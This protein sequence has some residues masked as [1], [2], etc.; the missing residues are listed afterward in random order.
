MNFFD[1]NKFFLREVLLPF[2]VEHFNKTIMRRQARLVIGIGSYVRPLTDAAIQIGSVQ[3]AEGNA[4][5]PLGRA[6]QWRPLRCFPWRW[7]AA[8]KLSSPSIFSLSPLTSSNPLIW[9]L[10]PYQMF[11]LLS[12]RS[13][14][15]P[16][17]EERAAVCN[18]RLFRSAVSNRRSLVR[19]LSQSC[20]DLARHGKHK[21]VGT[22]RSLPHW[23]VANAEML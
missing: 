23:A 12:G 1:R 2:P 10:L 21:G 13:Q 17:R 8:S 9:I 14:S 18:R 19:V 4:N 22:Q 5:S 6:F 7:C 11:C 16:H 15:R 20:L 3:P